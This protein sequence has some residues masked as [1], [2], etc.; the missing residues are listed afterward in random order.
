MS[1]LRRIS[2]WWQ[3][4]FAVEGPRQEPDPAEREL[5]ERLARCIAQRRLQAPAAMLLESSRPLNFIGSQVLAF[6]SPFATLVFSPEE[7]ERFVR[8]LE[9]RRGIDLLLEAL[10]AVDRE[11]TSPPGPLS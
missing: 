4:A 1:R 3:H 6:L 7:Y 11:G 8:L 9:K 2:Q 5:A 10:A